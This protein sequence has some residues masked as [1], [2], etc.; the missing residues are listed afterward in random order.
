MISEEAFEAYNSRLTVDTNNYK[1]LTVSQRDQ[2]K[3]YG[4]QAE[5][6]LKN[7]EL[8]MFIHY[9]KFQVADQIANLNQ[10]TVD[11]NNERIALSNQLAGIDGFVSSLQSAVYKKNRIIQAENAG[12]FNQTNP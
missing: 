12:E 4:S 11:A 1:R 10:H 3:S 5:A 2:V 8:A 9:F 7:R 6:L